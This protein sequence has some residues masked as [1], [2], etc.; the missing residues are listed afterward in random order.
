MIRLFLLILLLLPGSL[1]AS[2]VRFEMEGFPRRF[3]VFAPDEPQ[4]EMPLVLVLHGVFQTDNRM[5]ETTRG[6]WGE[7]AKKHNF[8]A[9][10]PNAVNRVWDIGQGT[11]TFEP[12]PR[13]DD[14]AYLDQVIGLTA[15]QYRIDR[16]R[17]F[18]VGFSL[19]AQ[20][21]FAYACQRGGIRGIATVSMPLPK[22][23][24]DDCARTPAVPLLSIHGTND[25]VIPAEGGDLPMQGDTVLSLISQQDTI[26]MFAGKAGCTGPGELKSYDRR[27]DDTKANFTRLA[28]CSVPI[29]TLSIEGLGHKWPGGGPDL[30]VAVLGR[31]TEEVEGTAFV[32]SFFSSIR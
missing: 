13:R 26:D 18:M 14:I 19:G 16:D 8:V 11:G 15:Q 3:Q 23:L 24:L 10:F 20:M 12:S 28:G 1:A 5:I 7:F 25:P 27:D 2:E 22:A 29:W 6:K 21:S 17:I 31:G 4:G 9:V 32:W 30:P